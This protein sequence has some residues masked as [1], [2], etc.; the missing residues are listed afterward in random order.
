MPPSAPITPQ[1]V[2]YRAEDN[3]T[4]AY[5]N[6]RYTNSHPQPHPSQANPYDSDAEPL[7]PVP[8]AVS[9]HDHVLDEEA[10]KHFTATGRPMPVFKQSSLQ[11][12][13]GDMYSLPQLLPKQYTDDSIIPAII[14]NVIP[15][16]PP[17][18]TPPSS[19]PKS[20]FLGKLRRKSADGSGKKKG[21]EGGLVKV[22][23]MPR[24]EYMKYFARGLKGEYIGTE[25]ERRWSEGELEREF[26]RYVPEEKIK[27]RRGSK[28]KPYLPP[29]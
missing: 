5:T 22:V 2:A 13:A 7:I 20:T 28:G 27:V 18:S 17:S 16:S 11:S 25:P 8:T 24:R 1:P 26:K 6:M 15:S 29:S 9:A 3:T 14:T 4:I 21:S 12:L 10:M 19:K 23:Y